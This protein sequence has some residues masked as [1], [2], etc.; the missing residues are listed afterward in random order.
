MAFPC[1]GKLGLYCTLILT[2][3]I[4]VRMRDSPLITH[5]VKLSH[6]ENENENQYLFGDGQNLPIE[7]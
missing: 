3:L 4:A 1:Y 7:Y 2:S 5:P 6:S